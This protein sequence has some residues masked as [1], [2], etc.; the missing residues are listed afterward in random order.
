MN[1]NLYNNNEDASSICVKNWDKF[2]TFDSCPVQ[3]EERFF[4]DEMLT[5]LLK[6]TMD[7]K[8]KEVDEKLEAINKKNKKI[9]IDD[10]C[11]S[12]KK[13]YFNFPY[14]IVIWKDGTKTVVK[15]GENEFYDEEKGL[16]MAIIKYLCGNIGYYNKIFKDFVKVEETEEK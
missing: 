15:C 7:K 9:A 6:E 11:N 8:A 16:A 4:D 2:L 12:I 1:S 5:Y 14:T 13:V 10:F 3:K